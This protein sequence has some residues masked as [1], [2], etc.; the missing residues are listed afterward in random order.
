MSDIPKNCEFTLENNSEI[1][2][3][4]GYSPE[5]RQY[6][7]DHYGLRVSPGCVLITRSQ[8]TTD[9]PSVVRSCSVIIP[10][11]NSFY[12]LTGYIFEVPVVAVPWITDGDA[13]TPMT[14]KNIPPPEQALNIAEYLQKGFYAGK[15]N[16]TVI[17]FSS[18]SANRLVAVYD[19]RERIPKPDNFSRIFKPKKFKERTMAVLNYESSSIEW[20]QKAKELDV[21]ILN[22]IPD[23]TLIETVRDQEK[24]TRVNFETW[25]KEKEL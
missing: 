19:F 7:Q 16:E 14:M 21:L 9:F 17:Q 4:E 1:K 25:L 23:K 18:K 11:Q 6:I 3:N 5:Q 15:Y 10:G 8:A 24:Q 22:D 13:G 2:L 12:G 20:Q